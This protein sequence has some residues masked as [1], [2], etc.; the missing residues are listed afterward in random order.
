MQSDTVINKNY[1][2]MLYALNDSRK[3][4]SHTDRADALYQLMADAPLCLGRRDGWQMMEPC[5]GWSITFMGMNWEQ[6]GMTLSSAPTALQASTTSGIG[7]P[8]T[9]QRGNLNT[10]VP[11][12]SAAT[13]DEQVRQTVFGQ[14]RTYTVAVR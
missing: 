12:F 7:F 13:A 11:S 3:L 5:L 10:G 2:K 9:R 6:K 8:F 4:T 1:N 14:I